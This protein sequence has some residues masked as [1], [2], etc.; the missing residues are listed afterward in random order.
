MGPSNSDEKLVFKFGLAML[1]ISGCVILGINTFTDSRKAQ[2]ADSIAKSMWGFTPVSTVQ[3]QLQRQKWAYR[4]LIAAGTF[5]VGI[6]PQLTTSNICICRCYDVQPHAVDICQS[7]ISPVCTVDQRGDLSRL[8]CR[9]YCVL[10]LERV[11]RS[12]GC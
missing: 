4:K 10:V 5:I 6:P 3:A 2:L 1:F 11:T 12:H 8:V 9:R 7:C